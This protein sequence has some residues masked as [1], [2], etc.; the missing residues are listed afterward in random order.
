MGSI[1]GYSIREA[2]PSDGATIARQRAFMFRDMG[3][4]P[5]GLVEPLTA[6]GAEE[7]SSM[8]ATGAY[9]GWLAEGGAEGGAVAGVGILVRSVATRPLTLPSGE[10]V[11][12]DREGLVMNAYTVPAHRRRGLA[13][14]LLGHVLAW[15]R[16][17]GLHRVVL[18]ASA[19]GRALY[20]ELGFMASN[21]MRHRGFPGPDRS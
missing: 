12:V 8:L 18:H 15:T 14:A 5:E 9:H 7:F 19:E 10:V 6:A 3:S 17:Q 16:E 1:D 13:R 11:L 21:E 4:M 2:V 20:E